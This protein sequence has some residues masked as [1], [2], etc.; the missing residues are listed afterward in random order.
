MTNEALKAAQAIQLSGM[1][2]QG[3]FSGFLKNYPTIAFHMDPKPDWILSSVVER[4]SEYYRF[5][6]SGTNANVPEGG[7]GHTFHW[8]VPD[9]CWRYDLTEATYE[10]A[11]G[12]EKT[13]AA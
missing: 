12:A 1:A 11:A 2:L 5:R 9:L 10:V 7:D 3:Y 6:T 4:P 13:R 8:D